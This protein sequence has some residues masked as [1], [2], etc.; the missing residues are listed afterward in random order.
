M[1]PGEAGAAR[2]N[3]HPGGR[4]GDDLIVPKGVDI[5]Q[6]PSAYEIGADRLFRR[7]TLAVAWLTVILVFCVI[8]SIT[9]QAMPSIRTYGLGFLSGTA[10]DSNRAQF[11][12]LPAIV[13]TLY[14]SILGLAIAISL[15]PNIIVGSRLVKGLCSYCCSERIIE[16]AP[17]WVPIGSVTDR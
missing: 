12:I 16:L 10:W 4:P 15:R 9:R 11:G 2:D 1:T 8:F 7:C 17:V 14:S 6:P 5:A 3:F 13:G